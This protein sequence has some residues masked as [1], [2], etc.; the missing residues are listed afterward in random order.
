MKLKVIKDAIEENIEASPFLSFICNKKHIALIIAGA[1]LLWL[2]F[3][4][5]STRPKNVQL[6]K[7]GLLGTEYS[8]KEWASIKRLS[9]K[10]PM[11]V[12]D[13]E[14]LKRYATSLEELDLS[15][16]TE[17]RSLPTNAFAYRTS[18][19]KVVLPDSLTTIGSSA[20]EGCSQLSYLNIPGCLASLGDK[21]LMGTSISKVKLPESLKEIGA[22]SLAS[23]NLEAILLSEDSKAFILSEG[24]LYSAD[25]KT[26]I[27]Y[28]AKRDGDLF[29]VPSTVTRIGDNAFEGAGGLKVITLENKNTILGDAAF[30]KCSSLVKF[31]LPANCDTIPSYLF[32]GCEMISDISLPKN[33]KVISDGAFWG[34]SSL[35]GFKLP[36]TVD[37]IGNF[38]FA[39]CKSITSFDFSNVRN[40]G[41]AAF[42][43]CIN[44]MNVSISKES[45]KVPELAF[46][47][48]NSLASV[49]IPS[50]VRVI[51]SSAF[52]GCSNLSEINIS[53][54]V[55][56]IENEAFAACNK[57]E[58]ITIPSSVVRIS[59]DAFNSCSHLGYILSLATYP[60]ECTTLFPRSLNSNCVL[61]VPYSAIP[62]YQFEKGWNKFFKVQPVD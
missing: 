25:G 38:G 58:S 29:T 4:F 44:L 28:P 49:T 43:Y 2:I 32:E 30:K 33:L 3:I 45:Q 9:V 26:L 52:R 27:Q 17:L 55:M 14:F 59:G 10:G 57:L 35:S 61:G 34:C 7:S 46:S 13:V 48:C 31:D 24:V 53:E 19:H 23:T 12:T 56:M 15:D 6:S 47:G 8:L 60:P 36:A 16:V 21:A 18:L 20:F 51:E 54:G 22:A 62:R 42:A 37:S 11:D 40:Y 41:N 5:V 50:S 1:I 39:Y